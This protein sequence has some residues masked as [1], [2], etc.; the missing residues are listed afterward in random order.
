MYS[1]VIVFTSLPLENMGYVENVLIGHLIDPHNPNDEPLQ[2]E[3]DKLLNSYAM[4]SKASA[5]TLESLNAYLV[6][7]SAEG[8]VPISHFTKVNRLITID[9]R[10]SIM[11]EVLKRD[12]ECIQDHDE[13]SLIHSLKFGDEE[14]HGVFVLSKDYDP[15]TNEVVAAGHFTDKIGFDELFTKLKTTSDKEN[16]IDTIIEE[17]SK[18]LMEEEFQKMQETIV[19][20][21][22]SDCFELLDPSDVVEGE[23]D[24]G[25]DFLMSI[26]NHRY[27]EDDE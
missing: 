10:E 15:A 2:I 16:D 12:D 4:V 22:R 20:D 5:Y 11:A 25:W 27:E 3:I 23:G 6:E 1:A 19:Y 13:I 21:E 8:A 9:V 17:V 18:I 24:D 7:K 14:D 26:L